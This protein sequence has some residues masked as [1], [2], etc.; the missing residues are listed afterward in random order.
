MIGVHDEPTSLN[1]HEQRCDL[2]PVV[3]RT[4]TGPSAIISRVYFQRPSCQ[5]SVCPG[6]YRYLSAYG[7]A[8][9]RLHHYEPHKHS[10]D[11]RWKAT[12]L[13]CFSSATSPR[14]ESTRPEHHVTGRQ[15]SALC[16]GLVQLWYSVLLCSLQG[17]GQGSDPRLAPGVLQMEAGF[18]WSD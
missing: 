16:D 17:Q 15:N 8:G 13:C 14:Q 6:E 18:P 5:I 3:S 1:V 7:I 10:V 9:P 11:I 4:P 2:G 12:E